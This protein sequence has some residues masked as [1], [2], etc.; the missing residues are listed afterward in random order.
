M[1][2]QDLDLEWTGKQSHKTR[3]PYYAILSLVPQDLDIG[4]DSTRVAVQTFNSRPYS[5]V[6]LN[7]YDDKEALMDAIMK[8]EYRKGGSDIAAAIRYMDQEMFKVN[9]SGQNLALSN[10]IQKVNRNSQSIL[11]LTES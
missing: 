11:D 5:Q 3:V 7:R 6:S 9:P 10:M 1:V 8:I 4:L 2:S